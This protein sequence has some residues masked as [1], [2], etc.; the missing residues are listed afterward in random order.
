[1]TFFRETHDSIVTQVSS[2]FNKLRKYP[3][4]IQLWCAWKNVQTWIGGRATQYSCRCWP[5]VFFVL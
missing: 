1:L 4:S 3:V 5:A 2:T